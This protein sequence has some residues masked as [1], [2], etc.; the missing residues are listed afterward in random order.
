MRRRKRP[1]PDSKA[2]RYKQ[3]FPGLVEISNLTED[4]ERVHLPRVGV[5][6]LQGDFAAHAEALREAGAEPLLVRTPEAL[7]FAGSKSLDG[8]VLPGG[9]ST[10]FLKFLERDN[11]LGALASFVREKPVFGTCAGCILLAHEVTHPAQQSL[12]AMD[13]DV[14]RNAYGR[15]IDS[16]VV[17]AD[18]RLPGPPLEMVFIR[19]PLIRRAGPAVEVLAERD[20][21]PVLVRE[22]NCLASTFHPELSRD[23]RVHRLFVGMMQKQNR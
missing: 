18:T 6:A 3:I 14:E 8:L 5:L 9:E 22:G 20:G 2:R 16:A 17:E 1:A 12:D 23:R 13:I 7:R 19:A 4:Q 21:F 10:T 11:L 15:Q